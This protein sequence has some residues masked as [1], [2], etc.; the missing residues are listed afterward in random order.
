MFT[1]TKQW[2]TR[3]IA[4]LLLILSV[5][6]IGLIQH[7]R[8][9]SRSLAEDRQEPANTPYKRTRDVIYGRSYGTALT[10]DVFEPVDDSRKNGAGILLMVSGGWFSAPEAINPEFAR[11]LVKR[12]YTVFEVVHGSQP[13]YTIPEILDHVR[14]AVRYVRAHAAEYGIDPDRLGVTGGSAGGHLSLMLGLA[15]QDGDPNAQDP[16]EREP[17]KVAAVACFFPPTDFLNWGKP[18]VRVLDIEQLKFVYAAFD[19][20]EYSSE[21]GRFERVP[22]ERVNE[23]L[24]EI[25]PISHVDKNDPPVLIIHGDKDTLVPLQQAETLI[26]ALKAAGAPCRL[27]VKPGAGHGWPDIYADMELFA[28]WFDEHLKPLNR[29]ARSGE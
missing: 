18:G 25:S 11:P 13:K 17:A 2:A 1:S 7:G 5:A 21:T 20:K 8:E 15:A 26:S 4:S 14:R 12:G 23:I 16:V 10:M 6:G 3:V 27:V 29:S 9:V 19:F 24:K 28:D 22:A